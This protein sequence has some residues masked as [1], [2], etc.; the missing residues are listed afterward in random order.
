MYCLI[1]LK[2]L[3]ISF[4]DVNWLLPSISY[5]ITLNN[6]ILKYI[7]IFFLFLKKLFLTTH[8]KYINLKQKKI[9][10]FSKAF[11]KRS[12]KHYLIA[13]KSLFISFKMLIDY[14]HLYHMTLI[15]SISHV[16]I[17]RNYCKNIT[18]LYNRNSQNYNMKH[19]WVSDMALKID[20]A[21]KNFSWTLIGFLSYRH[22]CFL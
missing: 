18:T 9:Y 20:D 15:N 21:P 19:P 4:K 8:Q 6:I 14:Y 22:W 3:F 5:D 7:K 11:L 1:A 13:L 10:I 16:K 17:C 2:S 12:I